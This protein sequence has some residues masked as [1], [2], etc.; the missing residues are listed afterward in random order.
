M[1][2]RHV[3]PMK[4]LHELHFTN[5][6]ATLSD[7]I[8]FTRVL[9][10]GLSNARLLDVSPNACDAIE[11]DLAATRTRDF[12]DL[13]AGQRLLDGMD[14]LASLYAGHQFGHWVPQLGD[15]RAI[16]LGEIMNSRGERW[17]LQLKGAGLTP[18]S[19]QAD[20]R[21]VLRSTIREYLASEAMQGLGLPTTRA[22]CLVGSDEEV[23][24][25]RIETG[26][27][28]MRLAPSHLRF[29][30]FEVF[31]YRGQFA[32]LDTLGQY[33]LHHHYPDLLGTREP[34]LELLREVIRRTARLIAG[35]QLL[36]FA[37]GV[38]NTDNM[39]VLGLTIDYGP[40][41]FMDAYE[42][43][44]VCNHS[45]HQG[46]YAFSRQP[47]IGHW[48]LTCFAQAILPLLDA[49]NGE[50]AAELAR[51]ALAEYDPEFRACFEHGLCAKIG[52]PV[53][54]P[55]SLSCARD[56]LR[57]MA[58]NQVDYTNGFRSL[59]RIRADGTGTQAAR[60]QF[61]DRAAFDQWAV[62]YCACLR[63]HGQPDEE[64]AMR[65]N[66][67]NPR[68]VLRNYL[69][70]EVITAAERGDTGPLEHLRQVLA[71]PYD[72]QPGADRYAAEP[73]DWG[74]RLAI[75]CSS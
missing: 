55:A 49:D 18:Y 22:L 66:R 47:A 51:G 27:M 53:S 11:L 5:S 60:D 69:A 26:A 12:L 52:L 45:D 71:S 74:R 1:A 68:Y 63:A 24:R 42:P 30:S 58:A 36:G 65:M 28:L 72:D 20:G 44:W 38:M 33:L 73:P 9:P 50:R 25:E 39:S 54:Q 4:Q 43:D 3:A 29:G 41:G 48:N 21:A 7:D 10:S 15:G 6:L 23:Y 13:A 31:F 19:R 64:R 35:W 37:H 75:S 56:L 2:W 70:Q 8:F 14:P 57:R 40:Y 67:V 61:V 46:R 32:H 17:E 34:F 59:A 16:L 62:E